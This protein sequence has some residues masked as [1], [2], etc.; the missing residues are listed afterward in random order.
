MTEEDKREN[1]FDRREFFKIGLAAGLVAGVPYLMPR[2]GA[3]PAFAKVGTNTEGIVPPTVDELSDIARRYFLNISKEDIEVYKSICEGAIGS[4]HRV[5]ELAEPKLPVKYPRQTGYR[6]TATENPFN[7]W[8]WK[9]NVKGASSGKLANKKIALKDNI[10]LA[11]IPMMN[12]SAVLEGFVPDVDATV[13]TRILDAGGTIIGKAVCEDLCFSGGSFTSAT[14]PVLNPHKTTHNAGGSSSGSAVLV[15]TGQVDMAMGGDQGGSIRIPSAWSGCYGLK[16]THGLVP[17]TGVFP[18]ESTL[19]HTGPLA[20]SAMDVALLLEVVAGTD[21]FDPRQNNVVTKE[22]TK[23]LNGSVKDMSFGVVKEGFGWEGVSEKD[24]DDAVKDA[25]SK[26]KV[27][28]AKVEEVSIP[29]H[30]DGIHI[31]NCVATEGALAQMVLHD[32]MGL[33]WQGYYTT[34]IVDYYGRARR[35]LADNFSDTVKFVILL[36]QYMMDKYFGRYYAKAQNLVPVLTKGYDDSL[37]KYDLLV[38]PTIP[39]KATPI[40]KDPDTGAYF[41]TALGMIQNTSPFDCTHHPAMNVPIAKNDGLPIGMMLIGKHYEDDKV[42]KA[43]YAIE[44]AGWYKG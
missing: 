22:Y 17:Y 7:A 3:Q 5:G 27:M 23:L 33:N 43:A 39:M 13:A 36:G 10:C 2:L 16:P 29:I 26:L 25:C 34:S 41:S 24:V 8:Y 19:D 20:M 44:K 28:G 31:W 37:A 1:K 21:G 32:G 35:V 4:Y 18:I 30:R 14:G 40:P 15:V 11:G 38:M 42:L 6:P 9:C 12:G